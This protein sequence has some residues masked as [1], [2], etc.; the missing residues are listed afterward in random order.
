MRGT[1]F[2]LGTGVPILAS[3]GAVASD[4]DDSLSAKF[5]HFTGKALIQKGFPVDFSRFWRDFC[6][7][8]DDR[9]IVLDIV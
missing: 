1:S 5:L 3:R 2:A 8:S 7:F 9:G 4:H 6:A